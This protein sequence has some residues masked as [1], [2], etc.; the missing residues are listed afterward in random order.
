[1]GVVYLV[2]HGQASFGAA[3]YDVL[4]DR[5]EQQARLAGLELVRR[6][7]TLDHARCGSLSRQR[8]TA[9]VALAQLASAPTVAQDPR[10]NE[11]DHVD[12][13]AH[14]GGGAAQDSADP[15]AYQAALED[16]LAK[17]VAAGE[18]SPCAE[19]WPR[20]LARVTGALDDLVSVLGKGEQAVV[21]TSGGVISTLCGALLGVPE[22]GLLSLNR[23]TVNAG[24]SKIVTGRSGT[25]MLS[26]NEHGHFD[27]EAAGLLSYR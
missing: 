3:D 19:S 11:Y 4:S 21:F 5:G 12:I 23:V 22:I 25:T 13:A 18:S 26:F 14:H 2:R 24:I 6:E 20:F 16:A 1:M 7:A 17:W 15:R 10:W 27:G 9:A 8:A